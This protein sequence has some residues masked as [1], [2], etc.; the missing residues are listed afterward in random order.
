MIHFNYSYTNLNKW[1]MYCSQ[2]IHH[3]VGESGVTLRWHFNFYIYL[4]SQNTNNQLI[5]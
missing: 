4:D 3:G 5:A 1:G 2:G